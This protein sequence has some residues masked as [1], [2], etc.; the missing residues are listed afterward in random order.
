MAG[1]INVGGCQ[2]MALCDI[3]EVKIRGQKGDRNENH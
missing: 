1:K 2:R 3:I